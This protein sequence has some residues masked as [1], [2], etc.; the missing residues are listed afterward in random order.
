MALLVKFIPFSELVK[1]MLSLSE[2]R[3]SPP[4]FSEE[5]YYVASSVS[6]ATNVGEDTKD[7]DAYNLNFNEPVL[8][9]NAS[10]ATNER[11]GVLVNA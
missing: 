3:L 11:K 6:V 5:Q 7:M 2:I 1:D 8:V 4:S 10:T 9:F